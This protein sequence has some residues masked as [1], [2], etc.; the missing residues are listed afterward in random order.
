[1]VNPYIGFPEIILAAVININELLRIPVNQWE[2]GT[3]NLYHD[4]VTS[5]E[6]MGDIPYAELYPFNFTRDK[7]FRKFIT[8]PVSSPE[9]F[10][11]D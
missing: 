4:P 7:S 9:Y 5:P 1:M 10:P 8:A 11:M 2:P 6:S 3:L